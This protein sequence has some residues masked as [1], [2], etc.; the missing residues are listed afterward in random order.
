MNFIYWLLDP[1]S[2]NY[3]CKD[4]SCFVHISPSS[5][6]GFGVIDVSYVG[7]SLSNLSYGNETIEWTFQSVETSVKNEPQHLL[8]NNTF[9]N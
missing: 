8:A 2:G 3:L 5:G 4:P 7:N 6:P 9:G 1:Y